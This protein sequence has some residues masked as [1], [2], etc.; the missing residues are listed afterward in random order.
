MKITALDEVIHY[1]FSAGLNILCSHNA[2]MAQAKNIEELCNGLK[3]ILIVVHGWDVF[4][5]AD[6]EE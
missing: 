6:H 3:P 1:N 4:F 2:Q 5:K